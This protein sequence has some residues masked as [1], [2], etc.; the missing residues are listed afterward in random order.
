MATAARSRPFIVNRMPGFGTMALFMFAML[1]APLVLLVVFSFN[2]RESVA[3]WG[4]ISMKWY[5]QAWGDR[6]IKEA[7]FRSLWLAATAATLSTC[8]ATLA[9]IA[10]TRTKPFRGLT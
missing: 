8:V 3:V 4:G 1:Y 7:A 5:V 2:E 9:A 6:E 10:T